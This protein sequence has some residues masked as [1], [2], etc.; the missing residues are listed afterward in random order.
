MFAALALVAGQ[1]SSTPGIELDRLHVC[2]IVSAHSGAM[3][4]HDGKQS[5]SLVPEL[6]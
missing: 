1:G 2:N 6:Q 3:A 5:C 4:H